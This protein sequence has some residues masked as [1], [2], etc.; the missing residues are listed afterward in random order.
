MDGKARVC[1]RVVTVLTCSD[2]VV[3]KCSRKILA[4]KLIILSVVLLL[5]IDVRCDAV[6]SFIHSIF[7]IN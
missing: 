3:S 5:G 2:L 1:V 4:V 7:D 6:R